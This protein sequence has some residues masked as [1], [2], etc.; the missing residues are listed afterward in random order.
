MRSLEELYE[1]TEEI[2]VDPQELLLAEEEPKN[3]KEASNDRKWIEAMKV[4]LDSINKNTTWK[5]TELPRDHKAIG[6]KW[7]FKTK[8]DANGNVFRHKARLVEKGYVQ[9]HRID[10]DEVFAPVARMETVR[11][12]LALAAY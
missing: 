8:K 9:Q 10:F 2:Q 1:K 7:V 6:L 4:E 3:Y 5:L 11:L 12:M